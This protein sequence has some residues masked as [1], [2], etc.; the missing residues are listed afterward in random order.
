LEGG[1]LAEAAFYEA[2]PSS[3]L[4]LSIIQVGLSRLSRT[5]QRAAAGTA[6]LA[7]DML[8]KAGSAHS[9]MKIELALDRCR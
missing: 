2:H 8:I 6:I 5:I 9:M 7:L 3:A 1:F 4:P